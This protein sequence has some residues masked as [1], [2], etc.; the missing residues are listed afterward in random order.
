MTKEDITRKLSS[1]KFW[2]AVCALVS[3]LIIAFGGTEQQ[4][5]QVA[6]IIMAGATVIAYIVAE[7]LADAAG[8]GATIL[9]QPEADKPPAEEE[10]QVQD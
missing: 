5:A 8:A 9:I 1:R 7:G 10:T 2:L 6:S 3:Q 4:A